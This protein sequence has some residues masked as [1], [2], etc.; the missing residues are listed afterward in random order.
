ML[1]RGLL[2]S[3]HI[4]TGLSLRGFS[5]R[6][7]SNRQEALRWLR[8]FMSP[9]FR[10]VSDGRGEWR[11]GYYCDAQAF[12][13]LARALSE[14][15][16]LD[17]SSGLPNGRR[18]SHR[19]Y[20]VPGMRALRNDEF[21]AFCCAW[22]EQRELLLVS[23]QDDE[24]ARF[25]LARS[26]RKLAVL[27][28]QRRGAAVLH[29]AAFESNGAAT[30]ALAPI[31]GGKS[32]YLLRRLL[33]GAR[34]ISNDRSLLY[35]KDGR[36]MV[37]GLPN[38]IT[39]HPGTF[40]LFPEVRA[41]LERGHYRQVRA[42]GSDDGGRRISAL[43]LCRLTEAPSRRSAPVGSIAFI[44]PELTHSRP[45]P[46]D[47]AQSLLR[48]SCFDYADR[49]RVFFSSLYPVDPERFRRAADSLF[50]LLLATCDCRYEGW[51]M[52]GEEGELE[53][54]ETSRLAAAVNVPSLAGGRR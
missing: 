18:L 16:H 47:E 19:E 13:D 24:P 32:T 15:P 1:A 44:N 33:A 29:A 11:A 42:R 5:V 41:R 8:A 23:R 35:A 48:E 38:I 51:V 9:F 37:S 17:I 7:E 6:V 49:R 21:E 45:V 39:L 30:L 26:V 22:P 31:G 27:H 14:H 25:Y 10:S 28:H 2:D 36:V 43:Q 4:F 53:E 52:A 20:L 3:C 46:P 34:F 54:N 40:A 50:E 12:E